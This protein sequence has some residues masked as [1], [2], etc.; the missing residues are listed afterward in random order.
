MLN[1]AAR[2]DLE[3]YIITYILVDIYSIYGLR[4]ATYP[5]YA[6]ALARALGR[7]CFSTV[8]LPPFLYTCTM[9]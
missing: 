9:E 3:L 5:F 8:V 1:A 2:T 7:G 6:T 4:A